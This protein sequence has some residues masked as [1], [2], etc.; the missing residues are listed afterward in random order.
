MAVSTATLLS[1]GA[2]ILSTGLGA[3]SAVQQS[4]VAAVNARAQANA[5]AYRQQ[6]A[7]IQERRDL[8][9]AQKETEEVSSRQRALL[10][11]GGQGGLIQSLALQED[12]ETTGSR[13]KS[14]IREDYA[15][16]RNFLAAREATYRSNASAERRSGML[17][18]VSTLGKGAFSVATTPGLF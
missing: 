16:Q 10:A 3:V 1:V 4:G 14:R 8:M 18:A 12:T 5:E 17:Q 13:N 7:D 11:A 9:A 15:Y 6:L 2:T